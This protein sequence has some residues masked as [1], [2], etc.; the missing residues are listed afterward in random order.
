VIVF[1]V[2]LAV[3]TYVDRVC[4]SQ[5]SGDIQ[6]D[7]NFTKEDMSLVFAAFTLAYGLFEIPFGW[8]GDK[9]GPRRMPAARGVDVVDFSTAAT[10]WVWNWTS[11]VVL[12]VSF[13]CGRG[14]MFPESHQ[15]V[16][17]LAAKNANGCGRKD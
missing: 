14:G 7:L 4:I 15:G 2:A 8:L 1:A 6:R 3:I 9:Y 13:R 5:A 17:H 11:M 10:G 16:H 12:P